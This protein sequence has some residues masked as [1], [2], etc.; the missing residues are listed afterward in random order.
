MHETRGVILRWVPVAGRTVS[1]ERGVDLYDKNTITC[2][3]FILRGMPLRMTQTCSPSG[4]EPFVK[5][6]C[7]LGAIFRV[8]PVVPWHALCSSQVLMGRAL[9]L[10]PG[11]PLG[12]LRRGARPHASQPIID[13]YPQGGHHVHRRCLEPEPASRGRAHVSQEIPGQQRPV[14]LRLMA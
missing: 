13:R 7:S 6:S 12:W 4:R 9:T 3:Q 5:G 10:A 8:S 11:R 1:A 2:N 14:S